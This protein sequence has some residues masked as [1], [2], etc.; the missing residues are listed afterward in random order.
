MSFRDGTFYNYTFDEMGNHETRIHAP[1]DSDEYTFY[2]EIAQANPFRYRSYYFDTET[3]SYYLPARYYDPAIGRFISQDDHSYLDP[4]TVNGLNLYAYCLNNPVM[5]VDPSGHFVISMGVAALIAVAV[6]ALVIG[7]A[8]QL[9][10]NANQGKTG[11]ELWRGVAGAA[12]GTAVN[13]VV[14]CLMATIPGGS[15]VGALA[16]S[17][18]QTGVNAIETAIRGEEMSWEEAGYDFLMNSILM[19]TANLLGGLMYP[20][21]SDLSA[22]QSI[23]SV[24]TESVGMNIVAQTVLGAEVSWLRIGLD[25]IEWSKIPIKEILFGACV[26]RAI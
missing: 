10:A 11:S 3:G 26:G 5:N 1:L 14:V 12:L 16:G 8:G 9:A 13:A 15:A 7:G 20:T 22:L 17:L 4:E 2:N 25:S 21:G 6:S 19:Y 18:V 24:F 23:G